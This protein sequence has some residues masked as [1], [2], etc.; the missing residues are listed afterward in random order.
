ML[1]TIIVRELFDHLNSLRF[2]LTSIILAA[3]MVTNAIVHLQQYPDR[4]TTYS[5]NLT[6]TQE[7]LKS[8]TSLYE[9][10]QNGPGTLYKRPSALSFIAAGGDALLPGKTANGDSWQKRVMTTKIES[11][12]AL[13]YPTRTLQPTGIR[14]KAA[15]IDWAFIITY[16]LSFIPLLFTFDAISGER[17]YGTLR[18]CLANSVSR[19]TLLIGKF[20]GSL[21]TVL[22]PFC[23][24]VILNLTL[25]STDTWTQLSGSD[26]ARLGVILLI[27]AC[28]AAIFTAIGLMVSAYTRESQMS[29]AGVVFL[30]VSLVVFTPSTLGTL[31]TK[32]MPPLQTPHQF[33][34]EK[35]TMLDQE[36]ADFVDRLVKHK[37]ERLKGES[38]FNNLRQLASLS[39]QEAVAAY[40]QTL[41][42]MPKDNI[43]ELQLIAAH[44]NEDVKIRER[45]NTARFNA[46]IAQTQCLRNITRLSPAAVVQYALES[47]A[48]TG[49]NRHLQFIEGVHRHIRIFRNFI[50]EID[51]ADPESLHIIGIP[52]GMSKTLLSPEALPIFEDKII[53]KELFHTVTPDFLLL[54]SLLI[55]SLSGAVI[56]FSHIEV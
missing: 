54:L 14:P 52:Q 1:P 53:F 34:K 49:L 28:Y 18:L 4:V 35:K 10:L 24:A 22:I 9:L 36:S 38:I 20:L 19:P 31:S 37:N 55:V 50:T 3:L 30:W 7:D 21:V 47:M 51:R 42:E 43:E 33:Q 15:Q 26:F 5:Q 13:R 25:I 41:M 48:G 27:A 40:Q 56:I 11:I 16:L 23:F 39:K 2:A 44:V 6:A 46:Q 32:W 12:W 45:L 17:E 29:F 8:F